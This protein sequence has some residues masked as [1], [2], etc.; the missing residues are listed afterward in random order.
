MN[1]QII[2]NAKTGT[3]MLCHDID[4]G[5]YLEMKFLGE[6]RIENKILVGKPIVKVFYNVELH[7][8]ANHNED[9]ILVSEFVNCSSIT[10]RF[11]KRYLETITGRIIPMSVTLVDDKW[12]WPKINGNSVNPH[13]CSY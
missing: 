3:Y 8:S 13:L 10:N 5:N 7:F 1:S 4:I 6:Y 12:W 9:N 2:L 11:L